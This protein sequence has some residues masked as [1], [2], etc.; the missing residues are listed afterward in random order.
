MENW[1]KIFRQILLKCMLKLF[2]RFN[3][4]VFIQPLRHKQDAIQVQF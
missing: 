1:G 3:K 4:Q 2:P